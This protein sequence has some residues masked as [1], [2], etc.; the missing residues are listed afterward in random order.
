[1]KKMIVL[2]CLLLVG[3]SGVSV[4][5][6]GD[7]PTGAVLLDGKGDIDLGT[8]IAFPD[9]NF[10]AVMREI[11]GKD[12]IYA[13]DLKGV[14]R[15]Y[16]PQRGISSIEG[17]QQCVNIGY[18]SLAWNNITDLSPLRTLQGETINDG[19]YLALRLTGN[20]ISDLSPLSSLTGMNELALYVSHA[21][22]SDVRPLRGLPLVSL[23]VSYN[24]IKDFAPLEG[25]NCTISR[26]GNPG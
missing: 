2:I 7:Q 13:S 20:P 10:D 3:C 12:V 9:P 1:M 16:A 6:I 21:R 22:I 15:I 17:I 25:L 4:E 18:I 26:T 8:P 11:V 14:E 5:P 19:K 23:D 24:Q